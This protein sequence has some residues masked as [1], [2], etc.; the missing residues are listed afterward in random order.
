MSAVVEGRL[1]WLPPE[2]TIWHVEAGT[3]FDAVRVGR[4]L[5]V[6][7][8][9]LLGDVCGAVICDPWSRIQYFLVAPSSTR[10]WNVRET[11][12][13]GASTYVVVPPLNAGEMDLHWVVRPSPDRPFTPT[14][15]LGKALNAAVAAQYGTRAERS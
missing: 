15:Q 7:A 5:G 6:A 8:L 1:P 3:H 9:A 11:T 2:G 10:G 4:P 13:C 14:E 12:A